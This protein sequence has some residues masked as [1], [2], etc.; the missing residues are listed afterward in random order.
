MCPYVRGHSSSGLPWHLCVSRLTFERL[1]HPFQWEPLTEPVY[2]LGDTQALKAA[3]S[4]H[5]ELMFGSEE[6]KVNVAS[7]CFAV[8]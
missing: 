4:L 5:S 7:F 3:A 6:E 8:P 2:L 1:C